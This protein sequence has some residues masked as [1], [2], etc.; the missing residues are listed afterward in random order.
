MKK[1]KL[2]AIAI[3]CVL[4]VSY[5]YS[6]TEKQTGIENETG[7]RFYNGSYKEAMKLA[8]ET[9]KPI[10]LDVVTGWCSYCKKMKKYTFTNKTAADYFNT[11]FINLEID[12]E[13]GEGIAIANKYQVNSYPT[14]IFLDKN[15][16]LLLFSEGYLK[17][18]GLIDA[19]KMALKNLK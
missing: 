1:F 2:I 4:A 3:L 16:Q 6:E 9:N 15:E 11:N 10:M 19:G 8:A 12:A 18:E 7:I 5:S 13:N 14:L 17:P